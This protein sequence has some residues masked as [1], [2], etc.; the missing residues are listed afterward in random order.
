MGPQI[1]RRRMHEAIKRILLRESLNQP[2]MVIFEDLHWIDGETQDLLNLLV[3]SLAT[4]RIL[5][6]VN[7]RPEYHHQWGSRTH[8]TQLRLDPLGKESA[9]E[10]LD[11]LLTS[12][13]PATLSA[14]ASRERSVG[15][16]HVGDQVSVQDELAPLKRLIIERTQGNPFFIEEIVL[17]LFDDGALVRNGKVKLTRPAA[18]LKIPPTVQATL[19]ARIDRLPN[20][21]KDLLQILAVIGPEIALEAIKHVTGKSEEQLEALL[22]NLQSS[23]FIYEQP[24]VAGA[25][26][27][28]KHALT[29]EVSYN[30]LLAER[31]RMIHAQAGLAIEAVYAGQLEDHYSELAR[32][33]L[34]GNDAAKAAHYAQ[35]AAEQAL[36]HGAYTEAAN[37][38]DTALKVLDR[39]PETDDRLRS[40][41]AFALSRVQ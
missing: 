30:S 33:H 23:E 18:E 10:M 34:R 8:Y 13:A 28:F 7:Y 5:L 16:I 26:Y 21:G 20:A 6:L 3:D 4:A 24:T 38:I 39:L 11:A 17:A 31:R 32:H 1:R 25:E 40:E 2:L 9:G 14:G 27:V 36:G 41:L 35:L 37:L 15:D 19:A 12:P 22:S 29:Q